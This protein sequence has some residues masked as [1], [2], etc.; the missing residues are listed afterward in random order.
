MKELR[1]AADRA[2]EAYGEQTLLV[3]VGLTVAGSILAVGSTT[4]GPILVFGVLSILAAVLASLIG[5][6][7][8]SSPVPIFILFALAFYCVLQAIPLPMP[9]LQ[10]LSPA[11]A[12]IWSRALLPMQ[13]NVARAPI[14]LD[15]GATLTEA[16]KF[17]SYG[18][19]WHAGAVL[20]W[21]RGAYTGLGIIF[22]SA[23]FVAIASLGHVLVGAQKVWGFYE[24]LHPVAPTHMGPLLNSNNLAGY[25]TLGALAGCGLL[26][27][28]SPP[29][30]RPVI[31]AGILVLIAVCFRT[32]SRGGIAALLFGLLIFAAAAVFTNRK[33][34][35][36]SLSVKPLIAT[37]VTIIAVSVVLSI[38]SADDFFWHELLSE[39]TIKLK[40]PTWASPL[41]KDHF[42][43]G[44]GR[45]AFASV[46]QA[47]RPSDG[48]N[49]VFT[50]PENFVVQWVA[51]WG[52][53]VASVALLSFVWLLRPTN[54]AFGGS[55][56]ILGGYVG[57][58]ALF[59]QNLVD[60]GVELFGVGIAVAVLLGTIWGDAR[61]RRKK[62]A[63]ASPEL[64]RR[65]VWVL[66]G[67]AA[68]TPPLMA[69]YGGFHSV[70]L[71]RFEVKRVV[72]AAVAPGASPEVRR[73]AMADLRVRIL[74]HPAD[75]YFPLM[76][77][78]LARSLGESPMPWAQRALE[79]GPTVGRVHLLVAEIL[80]ERQITHQALL[81]LRLA[82]LYEPVL[83]IVAPR[84]ALPLTRDPNLL[85]T[86]APDGVDGGAVLDDM[87]AAMFLPTDVDARETL[88]LAA[89]DRDPSRL[90]PRYR[91]VERRVE[92]LEAKASL[93]A[94]REPCEA[95]IDK[96]LVEIERRTP[97]STRPAILRARTALAADRVTEADTLLTKGCS[98]VEM[99]A[100]CL[101]LHTVVLS[102][103]GDR[104]RLKAAV[105]A[106]VASSCNNKKSCAQANGFAAHLYAERHDWQQAMGFAQKAD[107]ES[108]AE[109][110]W[111]DI[112]AA[113]ETAGA[114]PIAVDALDH[115]VRMRSGA[116]ADLDAR[117]A[118]AKAKSLRGRK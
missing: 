14:S 78:T 12:D 106:F 57:I 55:P 41:V 20:S 94:E 76:G 73:A 109:D 15:P 91:I 42:R 43:F 104:T 90:G 29:V 26:A 72:S 80:A 88:D 30:G 93:C 108:P 47:Y 102:K 50:H 37:F 117:I 45:G 103:L 61:R 85:M 2:L 4:P 54:M 16:M 33:S 40:V 82:V 19:L 34:R 63:P 39:N 58:A 86:I 22:L 27:A 8:R 114:Y 51:E 74:R 84:V 11:S 17:A 60:L 44:V 52:V 89:I 7:P 56:A 95:A 49:I 3:L 59:L 38:T 35:A 31:G 110:W 66:T 96:Q 81:E 77:A 28:K 99:R 87:A 115:V 111:F 5:G 23:F 113:A 71:D 116:D 67:L 69:A 36:V 48:Q 70:D 46:F 105:D 83:S 79:R 92:A 107:H 13:Q 32:A 68:A 9:W 97:T 101:K 98:G 53:P 10:K 18:C 21:K 6:R 100:D 65:A 25:L 118:A 112:A 64:P 24:P 62:Y 75:Y 1:E